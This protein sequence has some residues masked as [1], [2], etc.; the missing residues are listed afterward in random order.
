MTN[1]VAR[2][3]LNDRGFK[4]L[5]SSEGAV[6]VVHKRK[7]IGEL[8]ISISRLKGYIGRNDKKIAKKEAKLAEIDSISYVKKLLSF[9]KIKKERAVL[10]DEIAAIKEQSTGYDTEIKNAEYEIIFLRN[11]IK[12]FSKKLEA[13]GLTVEDI[14]EEYKEIVAELKQREESKKSAPANVSGQAAE[15]ISVAAKS[16]KPERQT[17]LQ[18]FKAR[19]AKH[20]E[21]VA[22][23]QNG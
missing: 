5:E 12:R 19:Q 10:E 22:S 2:H 15:N 17:P 16:S 11:E 6:N 21:I 18:K 23:R 14:I 13:V 9:G 7:K 4:Q 8:E 20:E 3:F 1:I